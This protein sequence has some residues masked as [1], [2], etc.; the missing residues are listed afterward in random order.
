M[1]VD[2]QQLPHKGIQSLIPY[3]P[4][5]PIIEVVKE[6]GITDVI[7]LASNENPLGCSPQVLKSLQ[8]LPH[9]TVAS[10]PSWQN[11]SLY[12]KLA[13]KLKLSP[14]ALIISHGSD[15]LFLL[16][17]M[18]FALHT[19][20]HLLTHTYAFSTYQIQAQGLGI[21]VEYAGLKDD[22]AVNIDSLIKKCSHQTGLICLANPNNPTGMLIKH[23][24]IKR[25]LENIPETTLLVLDEAY[26]E[27]AKDAYEG[28]SL[29]ELQ[30]HPNLVITRTF[31]KAYGLA[32]LRLGYAMAHPDVI[33][34]LN[35]LQL[36][37][38]VNQAALAAGEA[39]LEDE[40]FLKETLKTNKAGL[41]QMKIGLD[42]LSLPYFPSDANF[43]TVN[44]E[45]DTMPL[46]Q[47][48]LEKGIIVR[49]L[50]PYNLANYLRITIGTQ[51]QNV[52]LLEALKLILQKKE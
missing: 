45:Q 42:K 31:S 44:F 19:N 39:A 47:K 21:P 12:H 50:H 10:Y 2:F 20:K 5:K 15:Y 13:K 11:H 27:Y 36:P 24:E 29:A 30:N 6:F 52:R 49:P 26:Y 25:L 48:L 9:T 23:Q 22:S 18:G 34:I 41:K 43:L 1:S 37:F 33:A 8:A 38:A 40:T 32:G 51:D 14:D 17:L 46:F 35:K 7:K 3:K 4:G 16:L 28:N